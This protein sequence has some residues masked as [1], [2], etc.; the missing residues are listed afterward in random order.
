[1]QSALNIVQDWCD[2][3]GLTV[4]PA[5]LELVLFTRKRSRRGYRAPSM[6]GVGLELAPQVKFLGVI[7]DSRLNWTAH[8]THKVQKAVAAFW[9]CRRAAG[10]TWGI[11]PRVAS[12]IYL[13]V[14]RPMVCYAAVVWWPK[15]DQVVY[16]RRVQRIQRLACLCTTGAMRTTPTAAME[17]LLGWPPLHL[18]IKAE[19]GAAF[20]RLKRVQQWTRGITVGHKWIQAR[21]EQ[22]L[23][24]LGLRSD[25]CIR[26]YH[27]Q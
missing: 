12:W 19:A 2:E 11:S 20:H 1:M 16:Q 23:P 9:Q 13:A 22:E 24:I 7:L 18:Y 25:Y 3:M 5:K 4:N 27:F 8:V 17:V 21:M 6:Y 10:K 26:E 14:I 15:M